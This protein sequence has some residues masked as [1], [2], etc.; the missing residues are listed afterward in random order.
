MNAQSANLALHTFCRSEPLLPPRPLCAGP[1]QLLL[2]T[3]GDDQALCLALLRL[4]SSPAGCTCAEVLRL[5]IPCAHASALRSLWL[6]QPEQG[7][8]DGAPAATAAAFT[9]GLDQQ[10]RCWR[11]GIGPPRQP[12][13]QQAAAAP[14]PDVAASG[15]PALDASPDGSSTVVRSSDGAWSLQAAEAGCRYTQVVEPAA[16]DVAPLPVPGT[17]SRSSCRYLVAVAGRGTEALTWQL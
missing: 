4:D 6:S 12:A 8:A 16:L 15:L 14:G 9:L 11:L 3:G 5:S 7:P 1:G 2:L 17:P 13:Q 10:L